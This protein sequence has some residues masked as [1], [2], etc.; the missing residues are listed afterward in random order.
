MA[1]ACGHA[2]VA[3]LLRQSERAQ[4]A[5]DAQLCEAAAVGDATAIERLAGEGASPDATDED[6]RRTALMFAAS[7]GHAG[8]V[9]ALLHRGAE[10]DALDSA[11]GRT[12]LIFAAFRGSAECVRLLLKAGADA[13]LRASG[14]TAFEVAEMQGHAEVAALLRGYVRR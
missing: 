13:A 14:K 5:L 1:E 2:E 3:A 11:H 4:A 12:A 9:A 10:V 6:G 8:A 7:M